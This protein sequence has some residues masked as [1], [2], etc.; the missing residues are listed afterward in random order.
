MR[1]VTVSG[2]G[3]TPRVTEQPVP[4]PERDEV[5]VRMSAAGLNPFDWKVIDGL[6]KDAVFPLVIGVDG[7]GVVER[8]GPGM[9]GFL[10]GDA[11]FG[12]FG[13]VA[14]GRGSYAEMAVAG[15]GAIATAPRTIALSEAAAVPTSG[16]AA[17]NLL[18][19]I[20]EV[21]RL[22][23]VGATGGVG[24]F[25]TQFAA[26]RGTAVVATAAPRKADLM[27]ALGASEVVDHTAGSV[28][29]RVDPPVDALVDLV[30]DTGGLR[31]LLP[32][33]RPGG[34]VL[35][36]T[37]A[38]PEEGLPGVEAANFA[39]ESRPDLLERL[40]AEIDTG[41]VRVIIGD[42]VTLAQAPEALAR[43]RLGHATGKTVIVI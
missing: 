35:S 32:A 1:A 9:A 5:L 29:D 31:A 22:L 26:L 13:A 10:P 39:S 11:V 12:Q 21:R 37:F 28:A 17:L 30:G 38:V 20:G 27:R 14:K 19:R 23:V 8:V 6:L 43:N 34:T 4:V 25:L 3:A 24:T 36:P 15:S 33:V 16:M 42:T 2:F 41:R 40:A 18:D 7:A